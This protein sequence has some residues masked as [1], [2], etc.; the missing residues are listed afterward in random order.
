MLEASR[1]DGVLELS[2]AKAALGRRSSETLRKRQPR[3]AKVGMTAAT[4]TGVIALG[5][6]LA[7]LALALFP[8]ARG[9]RSQFS[10]HRRARTAGG[11]AS[12]MHKATEP[13]HGTSVCCRVSR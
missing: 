6:A 12:G 7:A 10:T 8:L 3:L 9:I 1:L 11:A 13:C 2:D 5:S 4:G